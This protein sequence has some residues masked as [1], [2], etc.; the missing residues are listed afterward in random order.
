MSDT[1]RKHK[2][3]MFQIV[4]N[5]LRVIAYDTKRGYKDIMCQVTLHK[6]RLMYNT[7]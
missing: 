1:E 7:E 4:L 3:I 6:Q 5:K 2:N